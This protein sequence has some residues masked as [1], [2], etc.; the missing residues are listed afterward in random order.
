MLVLEGHYPSV[1]T[2]EN[3]RPDDDRIS[4]R[5][6]EF[7]FHHPPRIPVLMLEC[8]NTLAP[9]NIKTIKREGIKVKGLDSKTSIG[10]KIHDS[11]RSKE[12]QKSNTY[13]K[14]MRTNNLS[15]M[16]LREPE[17]TGGAFLI[18]EYNFK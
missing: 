10:I 8:P 2:R 15:G 12:D 13:E 7:R 18:A 4:L 3:T 11:W 16:H 1:A 6:F 14:N 9:F 17:S 5:F